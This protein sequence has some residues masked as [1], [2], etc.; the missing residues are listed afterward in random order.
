LASVIIPITLTSCANISQY[1]LPIT[2]TNPFSTV[3][4]TTKDFFGHEY[5]S[6]IPQNFITYI[7]RS[8]SN[9]VTGYGYMNPQDIKNI[10]GDKFKNFGYGYYGSNDQKL[11]YYD[12][13]DKNNT[14]KSYQNANLSIASGTTSSLSATFSSL[15]QAMV[16]FISQTGITCND[17]YR[18]K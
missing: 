11:A 15:I 2:T 6:Y 9:S 18:G 8:A 3:L 7:N 12:T 1:V 16:H 14:V 13:N 10:D 4:G 17:T 5:N